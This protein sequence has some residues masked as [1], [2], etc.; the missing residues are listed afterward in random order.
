MTNHLLQEVPIV[1]EELQNYVKIIFGEDLAKKYFEKIPTP[2]EEYT[3]HLFRDYNLIRQIKEEIQQLG[4]EVR[5]HSDFSNLI[6]TKPKGPYELKLSENMKEIV[7]DNRA[8]EMICQGSNVFVPGVK[9]ANKVKEG[10]IVRVVNQKQIVVAR[11]KAM[12]SHHQMLESRRGIAAKTI[13]SRFIVPNLKMLGSGSYPAMFQSLPAYLTSMNLEPNKGEKILD[14]CAAPGNKT[15]HLNELVDSEAKIVAV[16]RSRKRL[17]KLEEKIKRFKLKNID[18]VPGNII[19]LSKEWTVKFDKILIDPPCTSLG[20]RPRLVLDV[21]KKTINSTAT[22]QRT[23]FHA[24][25]KLLKEEGI[26]IYSTCTITKEEN[27]DIINHAVNLGYEVIKQKYIA[28]SSGSLDKD[29]SYSV[30]RFIPG[31][32]KTPGFFIAKL[33]KQES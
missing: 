10:D 29:S 1:N 6:I 18:V 15:L 2:M 27:E 5:V 17:G 25:N 24:C 30:Q 4:F 22:Y 3:L 11:A 13:Q 28:S 20:L 8:A 31:K 32:D 16:D 14:C 21:E 9:R 7:V 19:D 33:K 26:I 23:I 12:M